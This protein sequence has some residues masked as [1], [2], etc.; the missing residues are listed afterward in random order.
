MSCSMPDA[1]LLML[2][3]GELDRFQT[4]RA[5]LHLAICPACRVRLRRYQALAGVLA[6]T[7]R[8]PVLGVRPLA[9]GPSRAWASVGLLAL[10]LTLL[11]WLVASN[12]AAFGPA[13][14]TAPRLAC[15]LH[16]GA[17]T[18]HLCPVHLGRKSL[19]PSNFK[20]SFCDRK[21]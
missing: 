9:G 10:L 16:A 14:S 11:G 3:H 20:A 15:P 1:D 18:G 7:Y 17:A 8:N 2:V 12:A 6:R 5:K 21:G 4:L 13:P 19:D